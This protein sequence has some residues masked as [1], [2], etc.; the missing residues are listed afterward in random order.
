MPPKP[1]PCPIGAIR[2]H[3]AAITSLAFLNDP[4]QT[5][6]SLLVSG[7]MDGD[8]HISDLATRRSIFSCQPHGRQQILSLSTYQDL[9][10]SQDRFGNGK[11][12]R[13][14]YDSFNS[15]SER[16]SSALFE[17]Q[18]TPYSFCKAS[19]AAL[20]HLMIATHHSE[21]AIA[22]WDTRCPATTPLSLLDIDRSKFGICMALHLSCEH[23]FVASGFE[24]GSVSGWDLRKAS[25]PIWN[26]Q[27]HSDAVTALTFSSSLTRCFTAG[28]DKTLRM[29]SH[30]SFLDNNS[31]LSH[32][33]DAFTEPATI[34]EFALR[35]D[36]KILAAASW[37]GT[38]R[39]FQP[40]KKK[41]LAA[42]KFH[43]ES[44]YSVAFCPKTGLLVS[45]GKD[46]K[47]A[48]WDV[49]ASTFER[50]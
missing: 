27:L 13:I 43:S 50:S 2:D 7:S 19:C 41:L 37:D 14:D 30:S 39:L 6:R 12:W 4:T 3:R 35:S 20:T 9:I 15:P 36:G 24:G 8:I 5:D 22:V 23:S 16:N 32:Q 18:T 38:V 21:Q 45:G 17:F 42:L 34:G 46:W 40:S 10:I 49:Y 26:I 1:S 25:E 44:C 31:A 47:V 48:L 28:A 33:S 11:V 29:L